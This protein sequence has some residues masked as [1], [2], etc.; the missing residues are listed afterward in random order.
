[1][2]APAAGRILER[3]IATG[4]YE[5]TWGQDF[6]LGSDRRLDDGLAWAIG[7]VDAFT[8]VEGDPLSATTK[9]RWTASLERGDWKIR[10]ETSSTLSA[11][12]ESFHITNELDAY[13]G[14]ARVH[15]SMRTHTV[16]RDLV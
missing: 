9:S 1:M 4:R 6:R 12:T 3:D 13:E 7:G 5:L 14:N 8:L 16:P 10:I 11:D 2:P 15:A